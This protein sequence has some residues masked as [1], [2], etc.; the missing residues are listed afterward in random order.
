LLER[1]WNAERR[2]EGARPA[3]SG[4]FLVLGDQK[5]YLRGVTYGT[6][7]AWKDGEDFPPPEVAEE[8]LAFMVENGVNALRTYTVPPRWLLDAAERHGLFVLVGLPWE[9]HVA[10]LEER[11]RRRSIE[12]R[13]R[14]G[15]RACRAHPAVLGYAVGNEIPST[16]ARWHGRLRIER[17]IERLYDAAKEE[18]PGA[19]VTYVN[20]P[21]TEYL[22][23]PFLDFAAFNVYLEEADRLDAYLARLHNVAGDRPIV[24]AELGLDSR[25]HG[26]QRQAVAVGQQVRTA[27]SAG[28]AGAFVFAWTDE[29]HRGGFDVEDWDFGLTDRVRRPKSALETVRATFAEGPFATVARW[30]RVSV[31]VCTHNGAAT[32]P[33]CLAA[34]RG[35]DYPDYEILV[36][37]DGSSDGTPEIARA[38]GATV[39]STAHEGLANA[40]NSA[41]A[42]A[43]GEIIAYLDDDAYPDPHWLSHLAS[44]FLRTSHAG[45]GGPNLAPPGDGF[46][47]DCVAKAPGGP[48]HVLLSDTE[49]EHIPGCN[50]AFRKSCL[51]EIGGFDPRFRVAGDDVDICWSLEERGWTLGFNA[52]AS[53]W[54]HRRSSLRGYLK[55]QREYGK[56][57]ALLERKWPEKYNHGGH[58]RW[59]GRVYG[60]GERRGRWRI[61]YGTWGSAGY[62][63]MY[64]RTAGRLTSLPM[65]PESYLGVAALAALSVYEVATEPIAFAVPVL[66]VPFSVLLLS[67]WV[68]LL[69][70]LALAQAQRA[71]ALVRGPWL[72]RLKLG[73]LVALLHLVQPV[74]RV[75]GRL[76]NG[77]VPWRSRSPLGVLPLARCGTFWREWWM[78]HEETVRGVEE[79][80]RP[81]TRAVLRGGPFHRWDLDAR[82]GALGGA[83]MRLAV[84]E[85]GQGR[86]LL[87]FRVS[88][89]PSNGAVLLVLILGLLATVAG[90]RSG[91]ATSAAFGALAAV[92]AIR[93]LRECAAG[94]VQVVAALR[95]Q[96]QPE[97]APE[98]Q[99]T[100][101]DALGQRVGE[102]RAAALQP[103]QLEGGEA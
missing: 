65:L 19:L 22:E 53:V 64:Q 62:Q 9:Q 67:A 58:L 66:G 83:R 14:A 7:R 1:L 27:F 99:E 59:R 39:I 10:F 63:S 87:R 46:V 78:S 35:L 70:G 88:P 48:Q 89:R 94:V 101:A 8:D 12:A 56:A 2:P 85:H 97:S 37:D 3:V 38:H 82:V 51:E 29:W 95:R 13:V 93:M 20:Y 92:V 60:D 84:E 11:A 75:S 31:A 54:H 73:S 23:L 86:Q 61:Y 98:R 36:V 100:I 76:Q 90:F 80:L 96:S 102:A 57:E 15:V 24:V 4:K 91:S 30:P 34:L 32:L 43:S 41:L 5:L 33:E 6:F 103:A 68:A 21:S 42:A 44:T 50:M 81:A 74:V 79:Q 18:D 16:I 26:E 55:Q 71:L 45:V 52:V 40:R 77:L 72:T 17:F 25:R 69:A 49:A 47:A 28:C